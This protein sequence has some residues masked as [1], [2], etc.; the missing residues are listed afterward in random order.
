MAKQVIHSI[1]FLVI[2]IIDI[3]KE[4]SY[5]LGCKQLIVNNLPKFSII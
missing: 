1:S 2:S 5:I 4:K 3:K